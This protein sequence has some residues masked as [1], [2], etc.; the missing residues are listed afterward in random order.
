MELKYLYEIET[1]SICFNNLKETAFILY[2]NKYNDKKEQ[3]NNL[4]L[5]EEDIHHKII[6]KR[7]KLL[8]KDEC[9]II[10]THYKKYRNDSY[11]NY[12]LYFWQ[13]SEKLFLIYPISYILIYDSVSSDLLYHFQFPGIKLFSSTTFKHPLKTTIGKIYFSIKNIVGSPI[14]NCLFMFSENINYIYCLDYSVLN[15]GNRKSNN[16]FKNK[17]SIPKNI[18]V[19]DIVFHPYE[20]FLYVGFSDGIVRIYD[21]NNLRKIKELTNVLYDNS[22][23]KNPNSKNINNI[24]DTDPVISLDINTIG[25]YLLEGSER[26]NIYLWDVLLANK[27]KKVL[28]KKEKQDEGIFSLKFIKTKQFGNIQKFIC[29]TKRGNIIIYFIIAKDDNLNLPE[30]RKKPLIEVVYK[31]NIFNITD[32]KMPNNILKYD[33]I[34]NSFLNICYNNNI[35]SISWPK[36]VEIAEEKKSNKNECTLLY[37]G[38][39]SKIY[40]FYSATYPNIN[41]PS[42]IQLKNRYYETYIPRV[43]QQNFENKI[44]YA[45]NYCIYLYDIST[46][47]HRKLINYYKEIGIK[48]IYLLKFDVKDMITRVVFFILIETA[49]HRNNLILADFDFI[50]NTY[51]KPKIIYNINDFVILGN[52]YLNL[53]SDFAFLLNRD[54]ISGS[55]LHISTGNI[56]QI[57]IGNNIIRSYHSPFNHG[58]CMIYRTTKNEFKFTQNFTPEIRPPNNI[59]KGSSDNNTL[60]YNNL[61]NFKCGELTCFQTEQNDH[62]IDIL[63][64]TISDEYFCATSFITKIN[65]Y[66]REMKFICSIDF[67]FKESPYLTSSL[68]FLD[69]TLIYSR[70][71]SISYFYPK[72]NVNQLIMRNNRKPIYIS[73]ILP[74][75]FILVSLTA[76][77]N[78]SICD[79]TSPMIN[80]LEPILVGYLDS[81][82]IDY[83][84]V[85]HC[86]I[87]MFTNQISQYFIEKLIKKNLKEIA[88]LFIDDEKSSFQNLDIKI[89]LINENFK[90]DKVVESIFSNKNLCDKLN[91]D[92]IMWKLNYDAN[93]Q[94]IKDLLIKELKILI[95]FGQFNS[96]LKILELLGDYP[97]S[98]NLLLI[99][100]SLEDF[101]KLKL[102]F[103]GKEALNYTDNLLI[104][105]I[106]NY[107]EIDKKVEEEEKENKDIIN[108]L[109]MDDFLA[110]KQID[111][112]NMNEDKMQHYHKVFDNYEGEH[113]IFGANLNQFKIN[114]IEDIE[115]KLEEKNFKKEKGPDAGIERR[116]INFGEKPFNIY[117]DDYNISIKQTQT[118]EIYSLILQKIENYYGII[119]RLSKNEKEKMN[120]MM[121]FYNYNLSLNQVD[122]KQ[123]NLNINNE[124]EINNENDANLNELMDDISEDIYLSAYY[125]C[126]KGDGEILEDITQNGNNA[127]IKCIYNNNSNDKN[128]NKK[129]EKKNDKK[130]ENNEEDDDMKN[131][132]SEVLDENRPLEYEDKWG[133]RS[134]PPHSIIFT[135]KLKTKIIINN[136]NL[137]QNIEDKFTIE[138]WIKLKDIINMNLFTKDSFALDI[139][140]EIFKLTF[141]GE[142]I[143]PEIIKEYSL[144]MDNFIHIAILYKKSLKNILILLN[145]E[146][147]VKF[148]VTL[149]GFANNTPLIFGNERLEGE[150]TEIRIWNQKIPINYI[151]EN[152]KSPLSIL[153]EN[154]GKLKMNINMNVN[155]NMNNNINPKSNNNNKKRAESIFIFGDKNK[156]KIFGDSI[157][158]EFKSCNTII[159]N[160]KNLLLDFTE[161]NNDFENI[162]MEEYPSYDIVNSK[163]QDINK[164]NKNDN[165]SN[166]SSSNSLFFQ[167]K[168]FIFDN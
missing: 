141:R 19:Y 12:L 102:K 151:R 128:K 51:I 53:D 120:K 83:E 97:K 6:H 139:D 85:K 26:G 10:N 24:I 90:F 16:I 11:E 36:F 96:A 2:K 63:F 152:Y 39:Q 166:E 117:S 98:I 111:L 9:N 77:S 125:H 124:E 49:L 14:E 91:L 137:L 162:N 48:N 114:Y 38:L 4:S 69:C 103:E 18:L 119:N 142:E 94:S 112:P 156:D 60:N 129:N 72:D 17:I 55:I 76:N 147:I 149:S 150:M 82:N 13:Q 80:P 95:D 47:R 33:I 1:L 67:N 163:S 57:K 78:I 135:K 46:S 50:N 115:K 31:N 62:I 127:I 153:A 20:K 101:D 54:M 29:L 134:P 132:W 64:N 45:D 130:E 73:G 44:Y 32:L 68:I 88:W 164:I 71:D 116:I 104:N 138:F 27:N 110:Q 136:S 122:E 21:Y 148:N 100:T 52:S 34:L 143:A 144:P 131:I 35:I 41:Y 155:V 65:I 146:E 43:G 89:N 107:T 25:S 30:G 118:I 37:D 79:I 22:D 84:L 126:D 86:V 75:R 66:N 113:F 160:N 168:D 123:N 8:Q 108:K 157:N 74:D 158:K 15:N 42:S 140:N 145:C 121:T 7:F 133:R 70:N 61:F 105:N 3:P 59:E 154:K 161:E 167:E 56:E 109:D 87:I 106:F 58:Y 99:S 40:F 93:Y 159:F 28:F 165:F 92:D 5:V 81:P 23:T